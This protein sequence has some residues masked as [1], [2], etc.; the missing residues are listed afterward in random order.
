MLDKVADGPQEERDWPIDTLQRHLATVVH[1]SISV[2]K[3]LNP[4]W[5]IVLTKLVE[6]YR[7][8]ESKAQF[9]E[10]WKR[11]QEAEARAEAAKHRN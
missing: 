2:G 3:R 11:K 7:S 4:R 8:E 9:S 10:N 1:A 5:D 6:I